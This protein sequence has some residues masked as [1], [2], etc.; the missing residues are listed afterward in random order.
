MANKACL[1]TVA[2]ALTALLMPDTAQAELPKPVRAMI[3]AAIATGD[4]SKVRTVID[5]AR[6][7]NPL[8]TQEIDAI[9]ANFEADRAARNAAAETA[10]LEAVRNADLFDLWSGQGEFGAFRST[11]N[12]RNVGIT[13]GV[14]L[15][16]DAIVWRNR[17]AA[18]ADY[19]ESA[20]VVT[21]EQYLFA[22]EPNYKLTDRLYIYGLGQYEQDRFQG[23]SSRYSVS[24]GLGYDVLADAPVTLSVKAGPAWRRTDLVDGTDSKNFAA[25]AAADFNWQLAETISFSQ[26]ASALIQ[27][28][29]STFLSNTGLVAK[30]S[31]VLSLRLSYTIEHDTAPPPG[32]IRTDTLSRMTLIYDF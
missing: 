4:D 3:D 16:R 19:Q 23:F 28:G 26:D 12:A 7:T 5:L 11:G 13:V 2:A 10:K 22:W 8:D 31:D 30:V 15:T 1:R 27:S 24:G 29:S 21:R 18:R 17:L 9:T 20:G 14:N 32:A 6:V 25:L